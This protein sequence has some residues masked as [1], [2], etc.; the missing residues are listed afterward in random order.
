MDNLLF[1]QMNFVKTLG[2]GEFGEYSFAFV[3]R[4]LKLDN[5]L[6]NKNVILRKNLQ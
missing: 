5:I 4:L 6:M 2:K 3:Y 1:G